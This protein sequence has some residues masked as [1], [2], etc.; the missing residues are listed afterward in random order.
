MTDTAAPDEDDM[1]KNRAAR[2]GPPEQTPPKAYSVKE[3]CRV[4][5]IGKTFAHALIS[6]GV[7]EK[8]Y[9]GAR[10]LV[11]A[12]S[13]QAW[14]NGLPDQAPR[15]TASPTKLRIAQ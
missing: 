4:Y 12:E 5:G 2:A 10:L 14:F 3:F 11:T 1:P 13:A 8:K 9:A 15:A 7:L 6:E